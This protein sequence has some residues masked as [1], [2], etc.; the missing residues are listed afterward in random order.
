[1]DNQLHS[2][3]QQQAVWHL[4]PWATGR[5]EVLGL[6]C[7]A[8]GGGANHQ[9]TRP[10]HS[11]LTQLVTVTQCAVQ[12][13]WNMSQYIQHHTTLSWCASF[14]VGERGNNGFQRIPRFIDGQSSTAGIKPPEVQ[15]HQGSTNASARKHR[16]VDGTGSNDRCVAKDSAFKSEELKAWKQNKANK[17]TWICF[18]VF[19]KANICFMVSYCF[20]FWSFQNCWHWI[21]EKYIY[22]YTN[23]LL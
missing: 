23:N 9:D 4:T 6:R 11:N 7:Q 14:F 1:M 13:L 17:M 15:T 19:K 18:V 16:Y 2:V 10:W 12:R 20:W 21:Q 22:I 8:I 3:P 5:H